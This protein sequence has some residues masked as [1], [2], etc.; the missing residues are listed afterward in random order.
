MTLDGLSEALSFTVI[1]VDEPLN[2]PAP[3]TSPAAAIT[4][5]FTPVFAPVESIGLVGSD[6]C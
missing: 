3:A 5:L 6:K 4:L 2:A 1:H